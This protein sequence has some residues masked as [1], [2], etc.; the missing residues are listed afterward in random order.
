MI[1]LS[2]GHAFEYMTASGALGFDGKGWPWEQPWRWIGLLNIAFFT[3]VIKT[4]TL[5]PMEGNLRWY[6]PFRCLRLVRDGVI[7][8][9]SLSN[10]GIDWWCKKIGPSVDSKKVSLV[11]SIFGEPEELAK[12][13][14]V[15]NRFDLVG[16]EINVSC[17]KYLQ[18]TTRIV[19]GCKAVKSNCSLP[20]ILKVSVAHNVSQIVQ[21]TKDL[22]EAFSINSVP[23]QIAFPNRKSPLESFG[24]GGVSGKVAQPFTWGLVKEL[25]ELTE[26]PVIG[27]SIW[28]FDDLNKVRNL[29]A[30]AVSFGSIFMCYPWR[31]T[32]YIRK[33]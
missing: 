22:I 13:A 33:E 19:E 23:W 27:P 29:G 17:P 26:I 30:K 3:S 24:G 4:L 15:L 25:T 31:P 7:N 9:V 14:K 11:A 2:N 21:E 10:P 28:D 8:A 20:L 6:N 18:D 5:F 32:V 1:R 12:M 16:L